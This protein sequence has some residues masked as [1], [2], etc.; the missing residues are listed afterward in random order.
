M[1]KTFTFEEVRLKMRICILSAFEDLMLRDIGPSMRIYNLA[2][3]LASLDN[4]VHILIPNSRMKTKY[5]DGMVVHGVKGLCP[6][7]ILR[8]FSKLLGV[9]RSTSL[10]FYDLFFVARISRIIRESDLVQIEQQ[11][12]GGLLIPIIVTIFKKPLVIDCHDV[13]QALRVK[14]TS[15]V[16]RI[17]ETFMEKMAYTYADAILTVSKRE[18]EYLISS[19]IG[20]C[21][22]KIIP[23]GV[24]TE[25]FSDLVVGENIQDQYRL[26]NFRTVIFVG[27]MEYLPNQEAVQAIASMIAPKVQK[28]I[29]GTEFLIVGRTVARI[30]SP[31]LTFTGVVKNVAKLLAN[32]DV[33]VAPLFHG[34]GTRLKILEYFSCG[35]PVVS[36]SVGVEGLEVENEVNV[37]IEDDI[38][39]FA[40]KVIKLLKDQALSTELGKAARKLVVDKYDWNKIA[41]HLNTVYQ[42]LLLLKRTNSRAKV[43]Y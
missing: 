23:N 35:L 30:E 26:R 14:H 25:A 19:G 37:L 18:K 3:G 40:V 13:F 1:V 39:E 10:F 43:M 16:R 38:K 22:I 6:I 33:A 32:A 31:N 41:E 11:S 20:Q 4:E 9:S 17:L 12:A 36:T 27:N 15:I 24:N 7:V 2:K 8:I 28:E 21:N 34:S 42:D 5:V 29:H